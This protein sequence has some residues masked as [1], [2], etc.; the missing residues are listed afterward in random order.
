MSDYKMHE[1]TL[2]DYTA[3]VYCGVLVKERVMKKLALL[4]TKHL[5][6]VKRLLS[7]AADKGEVFSSS[8]TLHYPDGKQTTVR[9]IDTET[10]VQE[11]IKNATRTD[12]PKQ[13]FPVFIASGMKEAEAMADE[14]IKA[15]G[16]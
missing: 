3:G 2:Y 13:C 5:E 8:W 10:D 16:G 11:R 6:D 4:Q 14:H 9:Y 1:G 15:T 12:K 7:D